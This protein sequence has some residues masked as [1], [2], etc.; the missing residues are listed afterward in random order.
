MS[1]PCLADTTPSAPT[2]RR[3]ATLAL[4]G[5]ERREHRRHELST[6]TVHVERI[7]T[8]STQGDFVGTIVDLSAGGVRLRTSADAAADV[9]PGQMIDVRL[10]L[11]EHA[12]ISPFIQLAGEARPTCEWVG[13][14][15]VLRRI[16]LGGGEIDVG[17]RLVG[18]TSIDRGM[19][20][21]YL[22]IQ[23]LA[24]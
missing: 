10:S 4:V 24:A 15:E 8:D 1:L 5:G 6:P 17:G 9:Q 7:G 18:M 12:G 19:L 11:P 2:S 14:I 3:A 16:D 21:L 20:G 13:R 22:S 23:P